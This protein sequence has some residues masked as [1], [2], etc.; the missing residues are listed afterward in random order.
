MEQSS[1]P[2]EPA[3]RGCLWASLLIVLC[4]AS[5]KEPSPFDNLIPIPKPHEIGS[6][7]DGSAV[8]PASASSCP[9]A[10]TLNRPESLA[11]SSAPAK[12]GGFQV[13]APA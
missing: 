1:T 10:A 8:G 12:R 5:E 11:G 6:L 9:A 13:S 3:F 2:K 7:P 4:A